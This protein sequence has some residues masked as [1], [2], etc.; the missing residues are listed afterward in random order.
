MGSSSPLEFGGGQQQRHRLPPR[1]GAAASRPAWRA[2]AAGRGRRRRSP[3]ES[4]SPIR[5]AKPLGPV[6]PA[7]HRLRCRPSR[8]PV[9]ASRSAPGRSKAAGRGRPGCRGSAGSARPAR[10][11]RGSWRRRS[12]A[13]CGFSCPACQAS[14]SP[15]SAGGG[16]AQIAAVSRR[17]ALDRGARRR[18]AARRRRN[19]APAWWRGSDASRDG[20]RGSAAPR[21]RLPRRRGNVL[22]HQGLLAGFMDA[23]AETEAR[24]VGFQVDRPAGQDCA[25]AV[26][27]AWV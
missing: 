12:R 16:G 5:P 27:S 26:T 25:N 11:A 9:R 19:G 8:R 15:T 13:A 24:R 20:W 21:R 6:D 10:P 14:S 17:I 1:T 22:A 4:L 2:V 23:R 3:P 7:H 18:A